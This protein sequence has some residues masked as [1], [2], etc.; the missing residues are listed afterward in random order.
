[1]KFKEDCI[2]YYKTTINGKQLHFCNWSRGKQEQIL[3]E[4]CPNNCHRYINTKKF[5]D[6]FREE[7]ENN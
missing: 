3:I 1:M 6:A 4:S 7:K 5:N 2:L